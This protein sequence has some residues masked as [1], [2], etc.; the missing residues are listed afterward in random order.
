MPYEYQ[1]CRRGLWV[2]QQHH[3]E[4]TAD[5][6]RQLRDDFPPRTYVVKR[7]V[8][9]DRRSRRLVPDKPGDELASLPATDGRRSDAEWRMTGEVLYAIRLPRPW[10]AC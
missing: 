6:I 5:V 7:P 4:D 1:H 10:T 3:G 9:S 8:P 2:Q